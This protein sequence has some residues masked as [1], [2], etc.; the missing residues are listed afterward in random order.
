MTE[1]EY[2]HAGKSESSAKL[3]SALDYQMA[4]V[5]LMANQPRVNGSVLSQNE[6]EEMDLSRIA[7]TS[8]ECFVDTVL[9]RRRR[10]QPTTLSVRELQRF[11]MANIPGARIANE[12]ALESGR[13]R[14]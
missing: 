9:A 13:R 2:M 12:R 3:H 11:V 4:V 1:K 7:G 8:P 14:A 10:V 6:L 5:A